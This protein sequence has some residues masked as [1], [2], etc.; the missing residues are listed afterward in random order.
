MMC[1]FFSVVFL[2]DE[3]GPEEKQGAEEIEGQSHEAGELRFLLQSLLGLMHRAEQQ[4]HSLLFLKTRMTVP[5]VPSIVC[6]GPR[7]C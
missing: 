7:L 3:N 2:K 4:L 6:S 1:F 5:H